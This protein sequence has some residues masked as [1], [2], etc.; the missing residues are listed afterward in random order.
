[1]LVVELRGTTT[2]ELRGPVAEVVAKVADASVFEAWE[3]PVR[4]MDIEAFDASSARL[5]VTNRLSG[6]AS[7]ASSVQYRGKPVQVAVSAQDASQ[8]VAAE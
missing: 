1:L 7:D 3:S 5:Y 2:L 6:M 8:F 4:E